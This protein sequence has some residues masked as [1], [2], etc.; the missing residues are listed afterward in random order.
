MTEKAYTQQPSV[1]SLQSEPER[2]SDDHKYFIVNYPKLKLKRDCK[3]KHYVDDDNSLIAVSLYFHKYNLEIDFE[4]EKDLIYLG[5]YNSQRNEKKPRAPRGVALYYL[6]QLVEQIL[7][8][9]SHKKYGL[10][11]EDS[12]LALLAGDIAPKHL[13][14]DIEKLKSYYKSLGFKFRGK[15]CDGKQKIKNFLKVA[16]SKTEFKVEINT[17]SIHQAIKISKDRGQTINDLYNHPGVNK[18]ILKLVLSVD[19]DMKL[20]EELRAFKDKD[21]RIKL[22]K[23]KEKERIKKEKERIKNEKLEKMRKIIENMKNYDKAN[24]EINNVLVTCD[25][26]QI[27]SYRTEF[28][29][30]IRYEYIV[31]D[32]KGYYHE[33]EIKI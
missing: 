7:K 15:S 5:Y 29:N 11:N 18:D 32:D 3:I 2:V 33:T 21:Y 25:K 6:K 9:Y 23:R 27:I 4:I 31:T 17:S 24:Q 28:S 26:K 1:H 20:E 22:E 8:R 19:F 12:K 13:N 14:F 10:L 16:K 30:Y